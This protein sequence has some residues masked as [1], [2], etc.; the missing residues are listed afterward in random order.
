MINEILGT[1]TSITPLAKGLIEIRD[2]LKR[3]EA[4]IELL[5]KLTDARLSMAALVEEHAAL[6]ARAVDLEREKR[7]LQ[8]QIDESRRYVLD[9]LRPGQ[10]VYRYQ[11]PDG[12]ATPAH[13]ACPHC[14]NT[15]K[16][17]SLLQQAEPAYGPILH[18]HQCKAEWS[19][20]GVDLDRLRR[21]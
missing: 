12:D 3:R 17:R 19:L 6:Q 15:A 11:P 14:W 7:D 2:E 4:V 9:K 5:S 18:C 21:A 8:A 1:L 16:K 13:Y 20:H 10:F